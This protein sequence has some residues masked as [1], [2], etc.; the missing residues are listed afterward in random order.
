MKPSVNWKTHILERAL[1]E[2]RKTID[3]GDGLGI[4]FPDGNDVFWL[5]PNEITST[6]AIGQD[7]GGATGADALWDTYVRVGALRERVVH[8]VRHFLASMRV[9]SVR[10]PNG[11]WGIESENGLSSE[12]SVGADLTRRAMEVSD[13]NTL[14][15]SC[16]ENGMVVRHPPTPR[17][18]ARYLA[19]EGPP[20]GEAELDS[21]EQIEPAALLRT[22]PQFLAMMGLC[23]ALDNSDAIQSD[24]DLKKAT[25]PTGPIATAL[26]RVGERLTGYELSYELTT[27]QI[28]VKYGDGQDHFV[29]SPRSRELAEK[30]KT[31]GSSAA[32]DSLADEFQS[33]NDRRRRALS[34]I[35]R[36]AADR[37]WGQDSSRGLKFFG[38]GSWTYL[39]KTRRELQISTGR[40]LTDLLRDRPI[41][42]AL[43]ELLA[44]KPD[45]AEAC[46][47]KLASDDPSS[48]VPP[49][50]KRALEPNP[51]AHQPEL[52]EL[53]NAT[54]V[55]M[56][57]FARRMLSAYREDKDI[58]RAYRDSDH[59]LPGID[60][61]ITPTD[62]IVIA[63][64]TLDAPNQHGWTNPDAIKILLDHDIPRGREAALQRIQS[65]QPHHEVWDSEVEMAW[66][67][68]NELTTKALEWYSPKLFEPV[69]FASAR[70]QLGDPIA[71]WYQQCE[72]E[73]PPQGEFSVPP[74]GEDTEDLR[75]RLLYWARTNWKNP[76]QAEPLQ[77][78][79]KIKAPEVADALVD[80]P[81][82]VSMLLTFEPRA[83]LDDPGLLLGERL[84]LA[85]SALKPT[86]LLARIVATAA[87]T[88]II[89]T[90][91]HR[92]LEAAALRNPRVAKSMESTKTTFETLIGK[93]QPALAIAWTRFRNHSLAELVGSSRVDLQACKLE[94][95]IVSP[96]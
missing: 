21:R 44:A 18:I 87:L 71:L 5:L 42:I 10:R 51:P 41:D 23:N 46:V 80:N 17:R 93:L 9:K 81:H 82:W 57:A 45:F 22:M 62:W 8:A 75:Q 3:A 54:V 50:P 60:T 92:S 26:L 20:Q 73:D 63:E 31:V 91:S 96:K 29:L 13:V 4:V 40:P 52:V 53:T 78:A 67:F 37:Q 69:P 43:R 58:L 90:E 2:G 14:V 59:Y 6:V 84:M 38:I 48:P 86:P 68:R 79:R 24:A 11:H 94:Y 25:K 33:I 16:F 74:A 77:T 34:A 7:V 76:P 88:D 19:I 72:G 28:H 47:A 70:A 12:I 35:A 27:H 61:W 1:I 55:A 15:R 83:G 39:G 65:M 95:S 56:E 32:G 89:R 66:R 36:A 30:I 49:L 64:R 85:W